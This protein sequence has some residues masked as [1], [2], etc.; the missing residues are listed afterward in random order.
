MNRPRKKLVKGKKR[1]L[2][3]ALDLTNLQEGQ[4][5]SRENLQEGQAVSRENLQEGQ[6]VSRENLQEGLVW[7]NLYLNRNA[8]KRSADKCSVQM[9]T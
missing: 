2:G 6:A 9:L 4:A 7:S 8:I 5:V 3:K 1:D